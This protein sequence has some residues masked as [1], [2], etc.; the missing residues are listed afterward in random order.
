MRHAVFLPLSAAALLCSCVG[1]PRSASPPKAPPALRS[2]RPLVPSHLDVIG[3]LVAGWHSGLILPSPELGPLKALLPR[4]AHQRYVSFGWGNR[5]FY[6]SAHPS[7]SD[8][9][10]ALFSSP[11]V[12]L[13][14]SAPTLRGLGP[15]GAGYHWLCADR[16]QVSRIDA[17]LSHAF[18]RSHRKLVRLAAGPGLDSAFYASKERYD[19]LHTCNTWT[20]EA[21]AYAGLPVHAGDVIFSS[22]IVP[23]IRKLPACTVGGHR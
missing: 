13:V 6:M 17:Y 1:A 5:R 9:I 15:N 21:L 12:V 10:A 11:S 23:L 4:Y 19:A 3:V 7:L 16:T 20:A 2:S 14:R 18:R 22:Q 8:A